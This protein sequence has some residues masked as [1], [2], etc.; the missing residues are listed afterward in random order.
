V[1]VGRVSG[2]QPSRRSAFMKPSPEALEEFI[3]LTGGDVRAPLQSMPT[4]EECAD[5]A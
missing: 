5:G 4:R 3:A 1:R 2:A